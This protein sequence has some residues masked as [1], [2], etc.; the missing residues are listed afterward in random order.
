LAMSLINYFLGVCLLLI[1][2]QGIVLFLLF[3]F[4]SKG[5]M[6]NQQVNSLC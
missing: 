3:N 5:W 1:L 4:D 2:L 6:L